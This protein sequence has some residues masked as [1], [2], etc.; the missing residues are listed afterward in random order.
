M[1][2]LITEAF[3]HGIVSCL[4]AK[5]VGVQPIAFGAKETEEEFKS[6]SEQIFNN[7][8]FFAPEMAKAEWSERENLLPSWNIRQDILDGKISA[9][10]WKEAAKNK[11]TPEAIDGLPAF[12]DMPDNCV[13]AV[14]QKLKSDEA[15]GATAKQQSLDPKFFGFLKDNGNAH[16]LGQHFHKVNDLEAVTALKEEFGFYIPGMS[17]HPEV[18]GIRGVQH[19]MYWNL[20]RK[21]KGCVGIAG[22][23]TW[24]LLACMPEKPQIILYNKK[25]VEKWKEIAAAYQAAG[26]NIHCLGFDEN[27]DM[28]VFAAQVEELYNQL[29]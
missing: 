14:I 5:T 25:G 13:M 17:Q 18:F 12:D 3:G 20:Y 22:T 7:L 9:E 6:Q 8:V 29:F 4:I 2:A 27:T 1:K 28:E 21:L 16:V 15:C 10:L 11:L 24:Y 19:K 23:H 26:Y